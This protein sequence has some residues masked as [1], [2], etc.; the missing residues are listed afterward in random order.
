MRGLECVGEGSRTRLAARR[1]IEAGIRYILLQATGGRGRRSRPLAAGSGWA[2]RGAGLPGRC[3]AW[4]SARRSATFCQFTTFQ[5][6]R[7]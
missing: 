7:R 2:K 5:I 1:K 6:S 4:A 3:Q